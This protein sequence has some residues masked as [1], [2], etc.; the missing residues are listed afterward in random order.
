MR[1]TNSSIKIDHDTLLRHL[2][3]TTN[4]LC[5]REDANILNG[6]EGNR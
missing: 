2:F 3:P 5:V 4:A 1:F 6:R